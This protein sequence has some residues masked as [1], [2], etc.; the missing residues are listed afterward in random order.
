MLSP[1]KVEEVRRLLGLGQMSQRKIAR[2]LGI[3]RG[4]VG[5]IATGKRLDFAVSGADDESQCQLPPVRC[6]GCGGMVHAPCRHCRVR[7]IAARR[8]QC[9][10]PQATRRKETHIDRP[11]PVHSCG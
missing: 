4:S 10:P 8:R 11:H 3:S 7:E 9:S 5:T 1:T 2:H 6:R